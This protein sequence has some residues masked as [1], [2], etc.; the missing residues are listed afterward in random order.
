MRFATPL[1]LVVTAALHANEPPDKPKAN[2]EG[3][4]VGAFPE[5][6]C[7]VYTKQQGLP[8]DQA[9]GVALAQDGTVF[10][11]TAAGLA[12]FD[13][14]KWS[15]VQ[16]LPAG[17]AR[18][19]S[20]AGQVLHV[21]VGTDLHRLEGGRIT[22]LSS[23]V[24]AS[25]TCL[26]AGSDAVWIGAPDGLYRPEGGEWVP[27][28]ELEHLVKEAPSIRQV[29]MGPG[30]QVAVAAQAGLFLKRS[31]RWTQLFPRTRQYSWA[32]Y[33]A[34]GVAF[35]GSGRLWFCSPQ[36]AGC[37]TG[38]AWTLYT[39]LQGLPYSD[40]TTAACG[41][42]GVVWFGTTAGAIRYDG[43]TWVYRQGR[44]WVPDDKING[45][46]VDRKGN[47]WFATS[48]GVG[49]IERRAMTLAE[50]AR[51]FEERI[52]KRHRRTPY[53]YV[54]ECGLKAPGDLS[55]G[56]LWDSD[57]DGLWT[58]MYGAGECFAYGATKDPL[59]KKRARAAFE[60]LKFLCDVTQ[61]GEKTVQRGFPA[62][63]ILPTD[64]RNPNEGHTEQ[65]DRDGQK[66]DRLW[67]VLHPRW[68]K[69]AD[70]KWYWKCD[71][72]SDELDGHYFLNTLYY[73]L[74]AETDEEKARVRRVICD[75]TDHLMNNGY[76]LIDWDGK[77]TR[78]AYFGPQDLNH[79]PDRWQ[80]RGMN[81][82]GILS[83]LAIAHHV[84]GNARY[85][86]AKEEL[87]KK[88][89]YALNAMVSV[90][91]HN[92]PGTENQSD[93]EMTIMRFFTLL[94]YETDP[95]VRAMME[96]AFWRYWLHVRR[97][98]NPFFNFLYAATYDPKSRSFWN[99][100]Y[101]PTGNWLAESVEMLKG[102]PMDLVNWALR[103]SHR[104]DILPHPEFPLRPD[105]TPIKGYMRDGGVLPIENRYIQ[106]WSEDAWELDRGGDGRT[107]SDGAYW[108]LAYY[109]GKYFGF[110]KE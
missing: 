75:T 22:K 39:G 67:K 27:D 87:V 53:G 29:A 8:G 13:G 24:P 80:E 83:Y 85:A 28:T 1:V 19:L 42:T 32:V 5:E 78:W 21:V 82:L 100:T 108:L 33:D 23:S 96:W 7:T 16:G 46:A 63:S 55:E 36:G 104:L 40:F 26:A 35:D 99:E 93:D 18:L 60:A 48:Q 76:S 79:N 6:V 45:I 90:K 84:S 105:G 68:P 51:L 2:I 52:D 91:V 94:R 4:R 10:A 71:T 50:K 37:L 43:T 89:S 86:L 62:R 70:G 61:G 98:H 15:I 31:G 106:H 97:S 30:R 56:I 17:A 11:G 34:R 57:N 103:N 107:E 92:G 25:A 41:E 72:S 59:A 95:Q 77:P 65:S 54:N 109:T 20:S 69:S 101:E 3:I 9:F 102:Q 47:A 81:S 64:G 44:R 88:H 12:R 49:V 14:G 38:A 110:I 73:D 66:G 58:G 74:A